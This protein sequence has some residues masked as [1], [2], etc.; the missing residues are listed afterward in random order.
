MR[1]LPAAS[2]RL[3]PPALAGL[4]LLAP[5][6]GCATA[7]YAAW[8]KLGKHKR[9]LLRDHIVAVREEQTEA[10]E[11][12]EDALVR[13][14][15]LTGFHGGELE[16]A[17][18][19]LKADYDRCESKADAVRDR[20]RTIE[21]VA[22][23]LFKEWRAEIETMGGSPELAAKSRQKLRETEERYEKLAASM[24]AA[25]RKMDPVLARFRD[26]VLYLKHNLNAA[27]IAGLDAE[28]GR[29]E[30]DVESLVAEIRRSSAEAD[31]FI[32]QMGD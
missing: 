27:A 1:V 9:D 18:N 11:Q 8:E 26:Q 28:V 2:F 19:S 15:G 20:I 17:Y 22:S 14:K 23:D 25:E 24:K 4:A 12:F 16:T 32:R 6:T 10:T 3:L 13:L 5:L 7:Y 29:I 30:N 31:A 21:S